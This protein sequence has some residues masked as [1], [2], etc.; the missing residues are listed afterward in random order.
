MEVSWHQRGH[1]D[2]LVADVSCGA[3]VHQ[4]LS[5]VQFAGVHFTVCVE[6]QSPRDC[7]VAVRGTLHVHVGKAT[8]A[9]DHGHLLRGHLSLVLADSR[10][11]D[12]GVDE[13]IR[14]AVESEMVLRLV[15]TTHSLLAR[16]E[17]KW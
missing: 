3:V 15:L 11:R 12:L 1:V 8:G 5:N 16:G 4:F 9:F 7:K 13:G 17:S 10:A 6:S 14:V 2:C